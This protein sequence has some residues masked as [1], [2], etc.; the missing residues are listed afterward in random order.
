MQ[1]FRRV[2]QDGWALPLLLSLGIVLIMLGGESVSQWLRYDRLA[3]MQGE[4]WRLLTAHLTHLGWSHLLLNL[5]GLFLLWI[6]LGDVLS[7]T[8]WILLLLVSALAISAGLWLFDPQLRWY[9]GLSGVLHGIL[10]GGALLLALNGSREGIYLLLVCVGKLLWEQFMGPMPG[11]EATA[12]G[13]VIV[14]AHLYG[15]VAGGVFVLSLW[16]RNG[17]R[18]CFVRL[19]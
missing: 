11:S 4:Y 17:W 6:L 10:L 12:G 19:S 16:S 9:V 8:G 15:A 14:N 3:I 2:I 13:K 1:V 18:K 7:R 5:A